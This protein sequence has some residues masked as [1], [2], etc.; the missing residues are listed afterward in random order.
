MTDEQDSNAVPRWGFRDERVPD[1]ND[2]YFDVDDPYAV[3]EAE[4]QRQLERKIATKELHLLQRELF[5][6]S[7]REGN[8]HIRRCHPIATEYYKRV[9]IWRDLT[10]ARV[11]N[12][13]QNFK[14]YN[15]LEATGRRNRQRCACK[16]GKKRLRHNTDKE[17]TNIIIGNTFFVL[18]TT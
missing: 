13:L 8:N 4:A 18:S 7:L 15:D 14:S 3:W 12:V 10:P 1:F 5:E 16:E 6:C 11:M 9:A 2:P 17:S